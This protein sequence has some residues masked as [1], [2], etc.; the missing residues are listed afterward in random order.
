MNLCL[1][2]YYELLKII[3]SYKINFAFYRVISEAAINI[4]YAFKVLH[5]MA[6]SYQDLNDGNFFINIK[7]GDVLIC[8]IDNVAPH[9]LEGKNGWFYVWQIK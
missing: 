7:A 6:Y 1:E 4:T 9:I 2:G 8:D 3:A 5:S